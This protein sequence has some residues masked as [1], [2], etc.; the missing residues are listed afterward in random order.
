[1]QQPPSPYHATL[2]V[3]FQSVP[4]VTEPFISADL[5]VLL[6]WS[7]LSTQ[8]NAPWK[9]R[10]KLK[11]SAECSM[12]GPLHAAA[13]RAPSMLLHGGG[14]PCCCT[15]ME[16]FQFSVQKMRDGRTTLCWGQIKVKE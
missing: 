12:E 3:G 10:K 2:K 1:M 5:T 11:L 15:C 13:W 7:P 16:G 8:H 9:A 4:S 14:P 6:M